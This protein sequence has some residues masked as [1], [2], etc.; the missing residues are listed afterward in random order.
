[1]SICNEKIQ[2]INTSSF[3][4]AIKLLFDVYFNSNRIN[5]KNVSV[6]L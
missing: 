1:M 6:T 4:E 5:P 2:L 3:E